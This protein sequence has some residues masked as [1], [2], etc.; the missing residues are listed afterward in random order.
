M[1]SIFKKKE[2]SQLWFKTDIHCH[3]IPGVDDGSPDVATSLG[4]IE[5]MQNWGITRIIASPHVTQDT[6]EN[7]RESLSAP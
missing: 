1:F 3:V 4:L 2:P 6:F 7:T 5:R